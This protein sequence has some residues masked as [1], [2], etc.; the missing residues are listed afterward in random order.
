MFWN[1][2]IDSVIIV[3]WLNVILV[4]GKYYLFDMIGGYLVYKYDQYFLMME[5]GVIGWSYND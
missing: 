5:N 1:K 2:L 4:K 3:M